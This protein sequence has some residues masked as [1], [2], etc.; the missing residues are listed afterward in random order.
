[1]TAKAPYGVT[2]LPGYN[3]NHQTISGPDIWAL[4]DHQ[5]AN[6]AHWSY[7]FVR[8]LTSA[9]QDERFNLAIGNLPLRSSEASS[10]AFAAFVKDYPGVDVMFENL[11]NATTAR[12]TVSGYVGLSEAVGDALSKVL[13][14]AAQPQEALDAAKAKADIALKEG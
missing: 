10:P 5:D 11:D 7:E 4:F 2:F 14:G 9:A 12:P 1:M 6:R 3:G 13:Q 8:W